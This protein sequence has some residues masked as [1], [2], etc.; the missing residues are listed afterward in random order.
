MNTFR[1]EILGNNGWMY[2]GKT[3]ISAQVQSIKYQLEQKGMIVRIIKNGIVYNQT[4]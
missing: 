1:I 4:K 3:P 2:Y